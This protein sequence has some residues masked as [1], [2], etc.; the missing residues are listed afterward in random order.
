MYNGLYNNPQ[1]T[2]YP[3]PVPLIDIAWTSRLEPPGSGDI[4]GKVLAARV[5]S[6]WWWWLGLD[7]TTF[8]RLYIGV[9][10]TEP[11]SLELWF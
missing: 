10:G 9:G 3:S 2:A 1:N 7:P 8:L 4:L 5:R 11:L 6:L